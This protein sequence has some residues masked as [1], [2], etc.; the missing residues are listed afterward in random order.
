M[1]R[2]TSLPSTRMAT[3]P[4]A[5]RAKRFAKIAGEMISLGAIEMMVQKLWPE[6]F[7]AAVAVQDSRKGERIV[8]VTTKLPA[9][10]EELR[11]YSRRFGASRPDGAGRNRQCCPDSGAGFRQDR[12][13]SPPRRSPTSGSSPTAGRGKVNQDGGA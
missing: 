1:I 6:D 8:L 13:M 4:F 3:S 11:E 10:R 7:H 2:A 12:T 5:G 9:L